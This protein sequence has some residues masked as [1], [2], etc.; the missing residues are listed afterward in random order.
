MPLH[1]L[2]KKRLRRL[3]TQMGFV[4]NHA[5]WVFIF[6][7]A[8]QEQISDTGAH[9]LKRKFPLSRGMQKCVVGSFGAL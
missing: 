9:A 2:L 5:A 6:H 8:C 3:G 4:I 1:I 7:Q